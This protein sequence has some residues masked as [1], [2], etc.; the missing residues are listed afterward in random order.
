MTEAGLY[1]VGGR[2]VGRGGGF[3]SRLCTHRLPTDKVRER[4]DILYINSSCRAG[5]VWLTDCNRMV[6]LTHCG[7]TVL[8]RIPYVEK[9][10]QFIEGDGSSQNGGGGRG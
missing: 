1:R 2:C 10:L 5:K 8:S 6:Q 9:R 4:P 3:P 7:A